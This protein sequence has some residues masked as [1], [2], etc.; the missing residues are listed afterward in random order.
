MTSA[1][2]A[3]LR[4]VYADLEEQL[5]KIGLRIRSVEGDGN[6]FFRAVSDQINGVSDSHGV[7]RKETAEYMLQNK[8]DFK[9]FILAEDYEAYVQVVHQ[10]GQAPIVI[11]GTDN[12]DA[13]EAHLT[14]VPQHYNSLRW[15]DEEADTKTA[16]GIR[17]ADFTDRFAHDSPRQRR[18]PDPDEENSA[19][20]SFI[21]NEVRQLAKDKK[22]SESRVLRILQSVKYDKEAAEKIL[23]QEHTTEL[24]TD[25]ISS[26]TSNDTLRTSETGED[27]WTVEEV[28]R[29]AQ[30]THASPTRVLEV[31]EKVD[32]DTKKAA[33]ILLAEYDKTKDEPSERRSHIM[34][35]RSRNDEPSTKTGKPSTTRMGLDKQSSRLGLRPTDEQR[36]PRQDR[37]KPPRGPAGVHA[38]DSTKRDVK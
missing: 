18:S 21:D 9:D 27:S 32:Y 1:E 31:L 15:Y 29:F 11:V 3:A 5:R 20:S 23:D 33:A 25:N 24:S 26:R 19:S 4:Q 10:L 35:L 12:E 34:E 28:K 13:P 2:E 16:A 36:L 37:T 6:C 7:Y 30:E 22:V 17:I 38:K 14:Y 8:E